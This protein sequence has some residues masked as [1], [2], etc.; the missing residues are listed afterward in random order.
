MLG[1]VLLLG[2]PWGALT[3]L[4]ISSPPSISPSQPEMSSPFIPPCCL[5]LPCRGSNRFLWKTLVLPPATPCIVYM[6]TP[7]VGWPTTWYSLLFHLSW[8]FCLLSRQS[9]LPE[10]DPPLLAQ[11]P[12][13][14]GDTA[15]CA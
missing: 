10:L 4:G 3:T 12:H 6:A 13:T 11:H 14:F 1:L 5:T 9:V 2:L 7:R 15:P 8:I